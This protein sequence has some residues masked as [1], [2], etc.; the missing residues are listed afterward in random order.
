MGVIKLEN[1]IKILKENESV[2]NVLEMMN[3]ELYKIK[4]KHLKRLNYTIELINKNEKLI[5]DFQDYNKSI[6]IKWEKETNNK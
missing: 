4:D 5:N 1:E 6:L 3:K 2:L